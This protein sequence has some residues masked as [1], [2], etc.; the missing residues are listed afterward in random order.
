VIKELEAYNSFDQMIAQYTKY[1]R[2][3]ITN[4]IIEDKAGAIQKIKS[5]YHD[6]IVS[7][8]DGVSID[9]GSYRCN[10]RQSNTEPK[11][12]ITCET[13]SLEQWQK[14]L[15]EIKSIIEQ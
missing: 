11:L 5:H 2:G 8:M 1:Y 10:V 7:E 14:A 3:P 6:Q 4:I 12:R 9:A 13:T 15:Q